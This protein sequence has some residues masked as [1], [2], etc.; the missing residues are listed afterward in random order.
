M[1]Q[2]IESTGSTDNKLTN[3]ER[4]ARLIPIGLAIALAISYVWWLAGEGDFGVYDS[5]QGTFLLVCG[6]LALRWAISLGAEIWRG[7]Q[8]AWPVTFA[9]LVGGAMMWHLGADFG[10]EN[11]PQTGFWP[12]D[13]SLRAAVVS[14]VIFGLAIASM[15][16]FRRRRGVVSGGLGGGA[17]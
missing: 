15:A 10:I 17:G 14:F 13:F 6:V 8:S 2:S 16:Y 3:S 9:M 1:E 4:W 7:R 12:F 5:G 11:S